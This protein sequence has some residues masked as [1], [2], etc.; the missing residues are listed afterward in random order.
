MSELEK[1]VRDLQISN[2]NLSA[3]MQEIRAEIVKIERSITDLEDI[4]AI[5]NK[6]RLDSCRF[7]AG[8][9]CNKA[10]KHWKMCVYG[11]HNEGKTS[12]K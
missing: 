12:D 9:S 7:K 3:E 10:C 2:Q 8:K 5:F 4:L 1:I 11:G 6:R